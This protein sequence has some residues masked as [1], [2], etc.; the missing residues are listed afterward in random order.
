MGI[1]RPTGVE[2]DEVD[3]WN[4]KSLAFFEYFK[5]LVDEKGIWLYLVD[6]V[7]QTPSNFQRETGSGGGRPAWTSPLRLL[8]KERVKAML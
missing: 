1:S 8:G 7:D 5:H 4:G 2:L 6:D 3:T